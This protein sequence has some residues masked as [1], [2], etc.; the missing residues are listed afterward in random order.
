MIGRE[1]YNEHCARLRGEA[2]PDAL[3]YQA[4]FKTDDLTPWRPCPV[5]YTWREL[6]RRLRYRDPWCRWMVIRYGC[7]PYVPRGAGR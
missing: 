2:G 6:L 5:T 3:H 1:S 4:W 7:D